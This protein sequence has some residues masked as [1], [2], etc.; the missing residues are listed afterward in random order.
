MVLPFCGS[1]VQAQGDKNELV[2][3]VAK[4][5]IAIG[6]SSMIAVCIV[7]AEKSLLM[8]MDYTEYLTEEEN[9]MLKQCWI[10]PILAVQERV[11][12]DNSSGKGK[13]PDG[14]R[15]AGSGQS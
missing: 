9:K 3:K 4:D 7:D 1:S 10:I 14:T 11:C 8:A 13:E 5:W 12:S 2:R 15:Q 6:K